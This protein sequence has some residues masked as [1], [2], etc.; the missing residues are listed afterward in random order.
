[1]RRRHLLALGVLVVAMGFLVLPTAGQARGAPQLAWNTAFFDFG[2]PDPGATPAATFTLTNSGGS[3][4]S[5]LTVTPRMDPQFTILA[6]TCT[7]NSLGPAKSCSVT[8][9]FDSTQVTDPCTL[10]S[11]TLTATSRKSTTNT[12]TGFAVDGLS[13]CS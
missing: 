2:F 6:D 13:T 9:Q 3:A 7:G 5:V 11:G 10:F 8:V 4:T 1:M 12:I